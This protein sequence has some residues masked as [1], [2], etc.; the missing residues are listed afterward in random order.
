MRADVL[1]DGDLRTCR[2]R[3]ARL[4]LADAAEWHCT[5]GRETTG[6]QTGTAQEGAAVEAALRLTLQSAR[7]GGATD[8]T[9]CSL[10]QHGRLP[11]FAG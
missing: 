5:D 9:I 3:R 8:L 1:A 11:H 4:G 7:K 6:S 2:R 10:D